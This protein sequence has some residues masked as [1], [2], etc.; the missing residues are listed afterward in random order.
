SLNLTGANPYTTDSISQTLS[1]LAGVS[2]TLNFWANSDSPNAFSLLINGTPLAGF[3]TSIVDNGFPG[4]TTHSSLFV[5][6]SESFKASSTSTILTFS[7]IS[8]PSLLNPDQ[9]GSVVIDNVS[10]QVTPE[11]DSITLLSTGFLGLSL[12]AFRKRVT[13][14]IAG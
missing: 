9:S 6:Y 12:L 8:D 2:Y 3:P 4:S 5:D 13:H 11:L 10:V 1:T 7:D 14:S